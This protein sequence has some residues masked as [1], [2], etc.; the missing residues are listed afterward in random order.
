IRVKRIRPI[1]M[2]ESA[3]WVLG[4]IAH[5]RL[6]E[7]VLVGEGVRDSCVGKIDTRNN[8]GLEYWIRPIRMRESASW[9]LGAIAHGR[10]DEGL[11]TVLVGEGV[12][13]SCVG[14]IGE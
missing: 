7:G 4:A 6:D 14:K 5:G 10:L 2:R 8:E 1:R 13:D 3:S 12:R 11:G 9:V